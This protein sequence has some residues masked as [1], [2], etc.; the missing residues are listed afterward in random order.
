M[1]KANNSKDLTEY[2]IILTS[3]VNVYEDILMD[4]KWGIDFLLF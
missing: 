2:G 1:R 4:I 3:C